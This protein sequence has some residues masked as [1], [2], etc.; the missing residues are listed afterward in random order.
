MCDDNVVEGRMALAE[1]REP[2]LDYHVSLLCGAVYVD[3]VNDIS[4]KNLE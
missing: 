1:P 2:D 3:T 4:S